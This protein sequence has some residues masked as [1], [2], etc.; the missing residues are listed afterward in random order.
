MKRRLT[1]RDVQSILSGQ[2]VEDGAHRDLTAAMTALGSLPAPVPGGNVEFKAVATF[3]ANRITPPPRRQTLITRIVASKLASASVVAAL[4]TTGG[5]AAAAGGVLPAPAQNLVSGAAHQLGVNLPYDPAPAAAPNCPTGLAIDS[6]DATITTDG[7]GVLVDVQTTGTFPFMSVGG[8]GWTGSASPDP[9]GFSAFLTRADG[10]PVAPGTVVYAGACGIRAST[11]A[12]EQGQPRP[13]APT[14]TTTTTS[15]PTK[16]DSGPKGGSANGPTPPPP[17]EPSPTTTTPAPT[18]T[19]TAP[20]SG[21]TTTRPEC[22]SGLAMNSMDATITSDGKGVLVT[23]QTTGTFP[24]MSAGGTGWTG[25]VSPVAGGFSGTLTRTD[26]SSV[27]PGTVVYAGSC[28]VRYSTESHQAGQPRPPA[29]TTTTTSTTTTTTAP[30]S[31]TTTSRQC[32]SGL[33]INSMD[34][35]ITPDGRGVLVTIHT[36]GTFPYMSAGGS[37]WTGTVSPDS[38]GFSG[39]LTRSDGSSVVPGTPV[40][41]G[42]CGVKATTQ[43]HS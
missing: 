28:G 37:G 29:P 33:A 42:A 11:E 27:V 2:P 8:G 23:I 35:T 24:Y 38:D 17:A 9:N 14:T 16:T 5:V 10:G 39:T 20:T 4:A 22:P 25:T 31:G 40:Y 13:P 18:T 7:K 26:G 32:P 21:T 30:S 36:T 12:H 41:A 19:T 15:A 34:A 6:M 3:M 43:A 1:G